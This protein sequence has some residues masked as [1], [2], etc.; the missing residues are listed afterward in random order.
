MLYSPSATT[1]PKYGMTSVIGGTAWTLTITA[2]MVFLNG[3]VKRL[4]A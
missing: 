2:L 1:S 3:N 4:N